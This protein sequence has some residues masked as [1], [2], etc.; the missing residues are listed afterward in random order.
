MM[1]LFKIYALAA[2]AVFSAMGFVYLVMAT[3]WAVQRVCTG[4]TQ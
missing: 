1:Y 2:F 3:V 4:R